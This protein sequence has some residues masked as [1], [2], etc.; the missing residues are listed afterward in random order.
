MAPLATHSVMTSPTSDTLDTLSQVFTWTEPAGFEKAGFNGGTGN[1]GATNLE[2]SE[3]FN[4][5]TY[6]LAGIPTT[7]DNVF[8]RLRVNPILPGIVTGPRMDGV[9]KDRAEACGKSV[10]AMK[11]DYLNKISLRR[12]VT[13]RDVATTVAILFSDTGINLSGQLLAVPDPLTLCFRRNHW[14]SRWVVWESAT[15]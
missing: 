14:R 13:S 11:T 10:E 2:R 3:A 1:S 15:R 12:M 9:I 7:E 8:V 6:A 5:T 4:S